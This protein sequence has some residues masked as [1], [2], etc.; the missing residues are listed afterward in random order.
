MTHTLHRRGER[1]SLQ[2]DYC[3]L[4]TPAIG[5]NEKEPGLLDK[6]LEIMDLIEEAG[7]ANIGSYEVSNIFDGYTI[8]DIRNNLYK[9]KVPRIRCAFSSKEKIFDVV[10]KIKEKDYGISVTVTGLSD[11]VCEEARKLGLEPHSVNFA[12]GIWGKTEDLPGEEILELLT[13]CGHGMIA[14]KLINQQIELVKAGKTDPRKAAE[15]IARPCTCGIVNVDR[16][17]SILREK[18]APK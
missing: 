4:I 11:I 13:Q 5:F 15:N 9:A 6:M 14:S 1:H 12:C 10:R 16:I 18:Y 7:P 8:K 3:L 17:E 2:N